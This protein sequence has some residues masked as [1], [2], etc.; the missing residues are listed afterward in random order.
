MISYVVTIP[1][2]VSA[3]EREIVRLSNQVQHLT[4]ELVNCKNNFNDKFNLYRHHFENKNVTC[5]DG[6][7]AG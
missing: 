2:N 6:T 3:K 4:R 7:T 5:N 1:L